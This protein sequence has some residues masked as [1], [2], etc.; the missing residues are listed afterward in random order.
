M[1][2]LCVVFVIVCCVDVEIVGYCCG[3]LYV[4]IG[5]WCGW[6]VVVVEWF[7]LVGWCVVVVWWF[8]VV[9][10]LFGRFWCDL[11][12]WFVWWYVLCGW[13]CVCV[14]WSGWCWFCWYVGVDCGWSCECVCWFVW[15]VVMV[16]VVV[17]YCVIVV[18]DVWFYV[19]VLCM[20]CCGWYG[21][22]VFDDVGWEYVCVV[23]FVWCVGYWV[24]W[25]VCDFDGLCVGCVW[26]CV[27]DC[28]CGFVDVVC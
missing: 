20:W 12:N 26:C 3:Y 17:M 23:D 14:G 10:I 2:G 25:L 4:G 1:C 15:L 7:G 8:G 24:V 19:V 11:G 13:S 22:W 28:G 9:V 18:V 5:C 27:V 16:G 21:Y 6:F